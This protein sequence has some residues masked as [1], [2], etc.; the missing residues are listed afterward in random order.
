MEIGYPSYIHRKISRHNYSEVD[1]I[2]SA[3]REAASALFSH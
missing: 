3:S 1:K 2:K